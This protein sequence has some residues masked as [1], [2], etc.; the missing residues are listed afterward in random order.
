M[1]MGDQAKKKKEKKNDLSAFSLG[2]FPLLLFSPLLRTRH[3]QKD[4]TN[5]HATRQDHG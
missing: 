4:P 1:Y 2:N 3:S 5:R